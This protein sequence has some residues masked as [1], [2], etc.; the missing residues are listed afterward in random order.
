MEHEDQPKTSF[1]RIIIVFL[2]SALVLFSV[3]SSVFFFFADQATLNAMSFNLKASLTMYS[4]AIN[5]ATISIFPIFAAIST[6]VCA[7]LAWL[8]IKMPSYGVT[9]LLFF[10][11]LVSGMSGLV[12]AA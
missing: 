7:G 8:A 3:A 11:W 6:I 10:A 2:I 1:K 12:Y 5:L 4:G 9:A